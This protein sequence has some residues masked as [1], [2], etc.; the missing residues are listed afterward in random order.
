[1]SVKGDGDR[2]KN[3]KEYDRRFSLINWNLE[4]EKKMTYRPWRKKEIKTKDGYSL[5][6]MPDHPAANIN[7]YVFKHRLLAEK[8]LGRYLKP[9]EVV[10][11]INT[12]TKVVK[13]KNI[14][15]FNNMGDA[16]KYTLKKYSGIDLQSI[17]FNGLK[18]VARNTKK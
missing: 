9:S 12:K 3:K 11:F 15:I 6:S 8:L 18:D 10:C 5:I 4:R 1:M 16:S 2:T 17:V 13:A 14:I 7:G